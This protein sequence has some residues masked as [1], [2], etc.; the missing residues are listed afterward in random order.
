MTRPFVAFT[1]AAVV[2][3]CVAAMGT[4]GALAGLAGAR[5]DGRRPKRWYLLMLAA[6]AWGAVAA[7]LVC[8]V[9]GP[10]LTTVGGGSTG[11]VSPSSPSRRTSPTSASSGGWSSG[12]PGG[13]PSPSPMPRPTPTR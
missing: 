12:A 6:F 13:A 7:P 4:A 9:I 3:S 11:A 1:A 2:V 10:V 8:V 5:L